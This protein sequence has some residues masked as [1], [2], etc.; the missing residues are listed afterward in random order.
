[1]NPQPNWGPKPK[2]TGIKT[3]GAL[4]RK[5]PDEGSEGN[6]NGKAGNDSKNHE[7]ANDFHHEKT[8]DQEEPTSLK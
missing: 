1:M 7:S 4:K 3:S 8:L 6:E 2:A 5:S